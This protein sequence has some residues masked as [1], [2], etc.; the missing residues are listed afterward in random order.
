MYETLK[1][2]RR[3]F[4]TR[5]VMSELKDEYDDALRQLM[6]RWVKLERKLALGLTTE[7]QHCEE[8]RS[9]GALTVL[10]ATGEKTK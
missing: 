7:L 1:E 6:L 5:A 9:E 8:E 3:K 4:Y 2:L 10:C